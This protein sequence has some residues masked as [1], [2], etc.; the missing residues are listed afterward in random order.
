[1]KAAI[2]TIFCAVFSLQSLPNVPFEV[3][4]SAC[5]S[6]RSEIVAADKD[7]Q[8][9]KSLYENYQNNFQLA[10]EYK[11]P[12][13]IHL[14]WLGSPLPAKCKEMAD[15]WEKFHPD[16]TIKV[17][18]DEDA[19][20]FGLTNKKSFDRAQ[21][22]GE[23]SDIFR[24]EILYRHGGLYVDTDFECI[25]PFD[26]LHRSCEFFC[27]L[28]QNEMPYL[29]IGLIGS[30]PGHPILKATIANLR[31]GPGDFDLE[32][33]MRETGVY[34]FTKMFFE[35]A[36]LCP[37]NTVVPFPMTYFYPFPGWQRFRKDT[38]AIKSEYVRPES[39]AIHY[40]ATSWQK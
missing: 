38:I 3:S 20:S 9:V 16:W 10:K 4:M 8:F 13:L 5:Y 30:V 35:H 25:R 39:M 12:K 24:Y 18:D 36:P 1:M 7:W 14:I 2:C 27:G 31:T 33:I 26:E 34:F 37:E 40:F 17:W 28:A 22:F 21:N 32:R 11:I 6:Y 19:A 15:S 23:K 29:L